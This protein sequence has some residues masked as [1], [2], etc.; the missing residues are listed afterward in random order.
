LLIIAAAAFF[1]LPGLILSPRPG[2]GPGAT[3]SG[4]AS[5]GSSAAASAAVGP[6]VSAAPTATVYVV[7]PGDTL[8]K[9]RRKYNVTME[10]LLAA[11]PQIKNAD[12]IAIGDQ[13][14][15]PRPDA[16]GAA[17]SGSAAP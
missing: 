6:S 14:N 2:A 13:I 15:I 12:K 11:N 8:E 17:A 9:I 10:Q 5:P 7:A 1:L 4:A 16:S 3:S